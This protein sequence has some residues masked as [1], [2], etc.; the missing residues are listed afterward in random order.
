VNLDWL[1]ARG[2]DQDLPPLRRSLAAMA[3]GEA[4]GLSVKETSA[5]FGLGTKGREAKLYQCRRLIRKAPELVRDVI[6]GRFPFETALDEAE[7]RRKQNAPLPP[8]PPP[9][10]RQERLALM[11]DHVI[12]DFRAADAVQVCLQAE[13][14]EE[15]LR[16]MRELEFIARYLRDILENPPQEYAASDF[17]FIPE[18]DG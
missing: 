11:T 5:V 3:Y 2:M 8:P 6:E 14:K 10:T 12:G 4:L 17:R 13:K 15:L 9:R 7:G 18:F 16:G 1:K